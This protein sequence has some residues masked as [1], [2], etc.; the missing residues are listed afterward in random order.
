MKRQ[1]HDSDSEC[2]ECRYDGESAQDSFTNTTCTRVSV[3]E[4]KSTEKK[5]LF[6]YDL[7]NQ[8]TNYDPTHEVYGVDLKWV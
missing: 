2:E 7:V 1:K 4:V 8:T 6:K 3:A 5:Y